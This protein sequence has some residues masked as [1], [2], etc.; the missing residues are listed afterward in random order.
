MLLIATASSST[1]A[2]RPVAVARL[3]QTMVKS[4]RG[5]VSG[6]LRRKNRGEAIIGVPQAAVRVLRGLQWAFGRERRWCVRGRDR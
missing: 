3:V 2:R 4:S 5:L 6:S 1:P